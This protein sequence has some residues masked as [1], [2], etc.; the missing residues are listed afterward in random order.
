MR[1]T[2]IYM[3]GVFAFCYILIKKMLS[4]K[5]D[6]SIKKT[7]E[8]IKDNSIDIK[9]TKLKRCLEDGLIRDF[10]IEVHALKNTSRMI[11]ALELS[12]S[13]LRLEN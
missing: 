9:S 4:E 10:T 6:S 2:L 5:I 8:E 11:G 13:F 1:E 12:E 7:V 3:P